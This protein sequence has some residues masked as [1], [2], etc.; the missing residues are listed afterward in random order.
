[1][2]KHTPGPWSYFDIPPMVNSQG[3]FWVEHDGRRIADVFQQ[4][5]E[6]IQNAQ[7]IAAAPELLEALKAVEARLTAVA[8]AFYVDGKAKALKA[9]FDGWKDDIDPA[10][11]AIAKA[12]G[13]K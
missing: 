6:T 13:A 5:G 2:S 8:W 12:E 11:A 1:M 7:L 4:G 3:V 10:R 9:V